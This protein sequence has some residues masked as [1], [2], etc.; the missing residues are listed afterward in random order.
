MFFRMHFGA[1]LSGRLPR[2]AAIVALLGIGSAAIAGGVKGDW[3]LRDGET[4][5]FRLHVEADGD[6]WSG[7]WIRPS[8]FESDGESFRDLSGQLAI[9]ASASE[10]LGDGVTLTFPGRLSETQ[11]NR[12]H[13][14]PVANDLLL[15]EFP[16][17]PILPMLL[18]RTEHEIPLGPWAAGA[19]YRPVYNRPPNPEMSAIFEA[20]QAAR[21]VPSIDWSIV[22]KEDRAR[23]ARTRQLLDT[24]VLQ[25]GT[26]FYHAAFVF[27]HGDSPD[28]YLIAHA[29]A[30][31]ASER[32]HTGA[33]W[34]AAATLDRYLQRI[35]QSQIFGTQFSIPPEGLATQEPY[36]R[37]LL[38]DAIR[39]AARVPT[40]AEQEERRRQYD[41][42]R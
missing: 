18:D 22:A 8:H 38:S 37:T 15:L 3:T 5:I 31:I 24:G 19:I 14:T 1:R 34:I 10:C 41:S 32:G 33:V 27:Q 7:V 11:P 13:I 9:P 30:M 12:L 16:G 26:D 29:L 42:Q 36:D 4:V 17:A 2:I 21:N 25:S 20:D 35:G 6:C 28:D 40:Q 39:R 23:K